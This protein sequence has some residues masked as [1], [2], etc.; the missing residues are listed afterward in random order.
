MH[1]AREARQDGLAISAAAGSIGAEEEQRPL[2][3]DLEA[4]R[5]G[6]PRLTGSSVSRIV[7]F[8]P[9]LSRSKM[10]APWFEIQ[11]PSVPSLT[12]AR[13]LSTTLDAGASEPFQATVLRV[14]L[15]VPLDAL[16]IPLLLL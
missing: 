5:V 1:Q 6:K 9:S 13:M 3:A 7:S 4:G 14:L 2:R 16:R 8:V 12:M 11:V 15:A 10:T